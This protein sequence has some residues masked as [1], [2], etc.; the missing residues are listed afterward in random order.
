MELCEMN[1]KLSYVALMDNLTGLYNR[2]GLQNN[3]DKRFE[4][5]DMVTAVGYI[6]LDNF[7]YYNDNFGHEIGD[8]VLVSFANIIKNICKEKGVGV[9]YGGDEFLII[10]NLAQ[11]EQAIKVANSIFGTLQSEKS[12]IP[13]IEKTLERKIEICD[14]K[15]V[16]CSV[17]ISFIDRTKGDK[18]FDIALK[19]ADDALYYIKRNGKGRYEVWR[20][21]MV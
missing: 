4:E 1:D 13:L 15:R 9:R 14:D 20:P 11:K 2:Q 17:G 10:M 5:K 12:F 18:A 7:M 8:L 6:D 16:S 21:E 3:L 19:Q